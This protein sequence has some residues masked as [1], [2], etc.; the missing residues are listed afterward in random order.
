MSY[1]NAIFQCDIKFS[2]E[3]QAI[4]IY[5]IK[6]NWVTCVLMIFLVLGSIFVHE[7]EFV[8][9]SLSQSILRFFSNLFHTIGGLNKLN[10]YLTE[11]F[12]VLK[13]SIFP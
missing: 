6:Q 4:T 3:Y 13:W 7:I 12:H 2:S 10:K 5:C 11:T 8:N 1:E 9:C